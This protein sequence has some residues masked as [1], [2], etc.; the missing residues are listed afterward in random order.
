MIRRAFYYYIIN[1]YQFLFAVL[2]ILQKTNKKIFKLDWFRLYFN[3]L[4]NNFQILIHFLDF[5]FGKPL[6]N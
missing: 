5:S 3:I 4:V 2:V 6:T 1:I